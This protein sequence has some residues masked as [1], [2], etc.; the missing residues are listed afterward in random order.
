V[1]RCLEVGD[2]LGKDGGGS[3][4][5]LVLRVDLLLP[6]SLRLGSCR[7]DAESSSNLDLL[8]DSS[9]HHLLGNAVPGHADQSPLG[10]LANPSLL[11][12]V[13]TQVAPNETPDATELGRAGGRVLAGPRDHTVFNDLEPG[14]NDG[15]IGRR[16]VEDLEEEERNFVSFEGVLG[17]RLRE[18]VGEEREGGSL[19][20]G[21]SGQGKED[22]EERG[23][24]L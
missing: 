2:D 8:V 14:W 1:E 13:S 11:S 17:G 19:K 16:G 3:R 23:D 6:W 7:R 21:M 22:G 12:A 9:G 20:V 18:K 5:L 4:D 24:L 15:V 10:S